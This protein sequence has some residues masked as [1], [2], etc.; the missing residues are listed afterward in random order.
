[1]LVIGLVISIFGGH[2]LSPAANDVVAANAAIGLGLQN[3]VVRRL[4]V[5]DLT[6]TVLTMTVTGIAADIHTRN[7]SP[8]M[9][10]RAAA[11]LAMFLGAVLGALLV[12]NSGRT[13]GL[14]VAVVLVAVT[15]VAAVLSARGT[16]AGHTRAVP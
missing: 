2:I 9:I 5:P 16:K 12:I 6:T 10:R 7:W 11:L 8:T 4:A 13:A 15:A 3:A 14:S 1:M